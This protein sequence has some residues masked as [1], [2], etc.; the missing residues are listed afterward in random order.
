MNR[1]LAATRSTWL[2]LAC[3]LEACGDNEEPGPAST[4]TAST[5]TEGMSDPK[6][7]NIEAFFSDVTQLEETGV[8]TFTVMV[9]DP[10]GLDTLVGGTLQAPDGAAI[11]GPLSQLSGGTFA[12]QLSWQ[13]M[14][15]KVPIEFESEELR[16]FRVEISDQDGHKATSEVEV[17]LVCADGFSACGGT[18]L[19]T[20]L[21]D[22]LVNCGECGTICGSACVAGKCMDAE[23]GWT[24]C[25]YASTLVE[26]GIATTCNDVC[27]IRGQTCSS[28]SPVTES[29]GGDYHGLCNMFDPAYIECSGQPT[30]QQSLCCCL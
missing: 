12:L 26:A 9:T 6:G 8:V 22:D 27:A 13:Q 14:N 15:E 24:D 5:T 19:G 3:M 17:T 18:C 25:S 7:P 21:D 30:V 2:T 4:T 28:F 20:S 23:P 1:F 29:C 16:T 10:D 11:Y